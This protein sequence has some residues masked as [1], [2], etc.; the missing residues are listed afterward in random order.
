MLLFCAFLSITLQ[1]TVLVVSALTVYNQALFAKI[2]VPC[3]AYGFPL[4]AIGTVLLVLGMMIC[5]Y[6]IEQSTIERSWWPKENA[7]D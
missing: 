2:G 5:S 1:L 6:T 7:I 3:K 4:F